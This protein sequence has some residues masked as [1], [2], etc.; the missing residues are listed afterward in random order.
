MRAP[1]SR[2]SPLALCLIVLSACFGTPAVAHET[3][4]AILALQETQ[5]GEFLLDWTYSSSL[6]PDP[7]TPVFPDHC[8]YDYPK[9]DCGETGLYGDLGMLELGERYSAAVVQIHRKNKPKQSF[10][11]TGANPNVKLTA[12]GKLPLRQIVASYIP[13]GFEH[14][15]LGVDHLLFVLGLMLLVNGAWMLTKTITSFTIAHSI[16]LAAATLGWVGVPERPVNAAIALSIVFLAVEVIKHRRGEPCLSARLPWAIAF[17]FGL[18]HGFGFAGALADIGLPEQ[19]LPWALLFFNIGVEIGQIAFVFLVLALMWS[20]RA[21][22]AAVPPWGQ[23]GAIY[24]MGAVASFW[25]LTRL[26]VM[27][28]SI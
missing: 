15:M 12:D 13:L 10:T 25:F 21:L 20:H 7:P 27:V 14:I 23:T 11:L 19:N 16:T 26:G 18:L 8:Q 22:R 4:I 6:T 2:L 5:P 17:G 3:P 9:L 24:A 1:A 28:N